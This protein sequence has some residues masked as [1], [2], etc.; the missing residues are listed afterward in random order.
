MVL[1]HKP[2]SQPARKLA[3]DFSASAAPVAG[4]GVA[5]AA[6][7]GA[8]CAAANVVVIV[9]YDLLDAPASEQANE[10]ER[11]RVNRTVLF[12]QATPSLFVSLPGA[13]TSHSAVRGRNAMVFQS[14]NRVRVHHPSRAC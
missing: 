8:A 7:A 12:Q 5:I 1:L 6:A 4:A 3:A 11:K 2:S 9:V 14:S 13:H 10:R